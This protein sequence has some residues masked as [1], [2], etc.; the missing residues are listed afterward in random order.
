VGVKMFA[1][2]QEQIRAQADPRYATDPAF[3]A[4]VERMIDASIKAGK[5]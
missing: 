4:T 3:R 1:T 5:Y 2:M